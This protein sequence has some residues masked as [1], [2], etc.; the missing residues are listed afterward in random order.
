MRLVRTGA[1]AGLTYAWLEGSSVTSFDQT[2]RQARSA[3]AAQPQGRSMRE[4]VKG[5]LRR[6]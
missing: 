6:R 5:T 1:C 2:V 3:R 4:I